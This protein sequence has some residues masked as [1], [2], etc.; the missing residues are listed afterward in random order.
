MVTE[1]QFEKISIGNQ[2]M[3]IRQLGLSPREVEHVVTVCD[4]AHKKSISAVQ[5]LISSNSSTDLLTVL[6]RIGSGAAFSKRPEYLCLK[7][8][9]GRMC[10][11]RNSCSGCS[12]EVS[13]KSSFFLLISEFNRMKNLYKSADSE[14]EKMKYKTLITDIIIPK[15]DEMLTCIK[16][17]Y[18]EDMFSDYEKLLKEYT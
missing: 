16:A 14:L 11:T 1:G 6:H 7:T 2:T 12:Y 4:A 15:L 18:G 8:A 5:A 10:D 17:T 9:F 3:M 13:T